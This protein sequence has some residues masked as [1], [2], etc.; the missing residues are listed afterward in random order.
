M[1]VCVVGRLQRILDPTD[2][3]IRYLLDEISDYE[4]NS[5]EERLK[6]DEDYQK[7]LSETEER[8]IIAYVNC[9]LSETNRRLFEN[10]FLCTEE[11]K[12]K[13]NLVQKYESSTPPP[14]ARKRYIFNRPISF[15]TSTKYITSGFILVLLPFISIVGWDL[16]SIK[17]GE[18]ALI[19]AYSK[20]RPI[21]ARITGFNYAIFSRKRNNQP[22]VFDD[23]KR[24][25]AHNLITNR[26]D[27]YNSSTSTLRLLGKLA[28]TDKNFDTAIKYFN[29]ALNKDEKNGEIH[30]DIAVALI[31]KE[32]AKNDNE[33]SIEGYADALEHLHKAVELNPNSLDALF[34]LA[35]CRQYQMLWRTAGETWKQYLEKDSTSEWADEARKNLNDIEERLKRTG[36]NREQMIKEFPE[37]LKKRDAEKAWSIF[38]NS[39]RTDGSFVLDKIIDD[40]IS[41]KLAKNVTVADEI[42]QSMLF[43]GKVERDKTADEFTSSLAQYYRSASSDQLRAAGEARKLFRSAYDIMLK[44]KYEEALKLGKESRYLFD[45]VGNDVEKL[46]V[47]HLIG[48]IHFRLR[49]IHT[50]LNLSAQGSEIC[51][52]QSLKWIQG[53]FQNSLYNAH[54]SLTKYSKA[55]EYNLNYINICRQVEN[56]QGLVHGLGALS[57]LNITLGKFDEALQMAQEGISLADR[58]NSPIGSY[59]AL[60]SFGAKSLLFLGRLSGSHDYQLEGMRATS[61][62][63][64]SLIK[65]VHNTNLAYILSEQGKYGEAINTIKKSIEMAKSISEKTLSSQ[66]LARL[67]LCLGRIYRE[68]GLWKES[69]IYYDEVEKLYLKNEIQE[70]YFSFQINKGRFL[71]AVKTQDYTVAEKVLNTLLSQYESHRDNIENVNSRNIFFHNEQKIYDVA[72]DFAY[73]QLKDISRSFNYSEMSRSRSLLDMIELPERKLPENLRLAISIPYTIKPL[74]LKQIQERMP[75]NTHILQFGLLEDKLIIWVISKDKI[76]SSFTPIS[77]KIL[78]NKINVYLSQIDASQ[79]SSKNTDYKQQSVDLYNILIKPVE[80]YLMKDYDV[81][82]I[83]D[84]LLN[85]LPFASLIS[86]FTGR[87]L[88][89]DRVIYMSP[90]ANMF[91]AATEN[92]RQKELPKEERLLAI[93]PAQINYLTDAESQTTGITALYKSGLIAVDNSSKESF[94]RKQLKQSEIV[95]FAT[96]Y[97]ADERS[98]MLSYLPLASE[99]GGT[100]KDRDGKLQA[101]ELYSMKLPHLRVAV[102]SGCQTGIERYY[103][104]EGAVGLAQAFQAIGVPLVVASLWSVEDYP[105]KVLMLSFHKHRKI[106]KKNTVN[107]LRAAQLE[108]IR[109]KNPQLRSPYHWA[110]FSIYGG[111]STF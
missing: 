13:H 55:K 34:N 11:R 58:I 101:Y 75:D 103:N 44:D 77:E 26:D 41:A 52:R 95:D 43:M 54:V 45:K 87:Y 81:C 22:L 25:K 63:D 104:G 39:R 6:F 32:R 36:Q 79:Y 3:L 37:A 28:L 7:K 66:I 76:K 5:I 60:F 20:E 53:L 61:E 68:L 74:S 21:E 23:I 33:V 48:Y 102:L 62:I 65:S 14:P 107:A 4:K 110:A 59:V 51:K 56:D 92:A 40:Y 89:E 108:M 50:S 73:F 49:D 9:G 100:S 71:T 2:P 94:V 109:S 38:K 31:A 106:G 46:L 17:R 99:V 78:N 84:K 24:R 64:S 10:N 105:I 82:I 83:P 85:R 91:I 1:E 67:Y 69:S 97:I 80:Q 70:I 57:E 88:I 12:Q 47:Q 111:H 8:L 86:S 93:G 98:P 96:H 16:F 15:S 30:N 29:L 35:L 72:T 42:L 19:E 90:S 27:G 18:W